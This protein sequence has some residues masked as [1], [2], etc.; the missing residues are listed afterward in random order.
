MSLRAAH[1]TRSSRVVRSTRSTSSGSAVSASTRCHAI[2][3]IGR[4]APRAPP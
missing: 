3:A 4:P 1:A 2:V